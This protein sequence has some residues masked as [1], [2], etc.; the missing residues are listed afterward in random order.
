MLLDEIIG[1]LSDEKESLNSALLKT[2]VL[3][4][5]IGK[6]D[7]ATWVTNELKGYANDDDVPDYR[8]VTSEPHAHVTNIGWQ[9]FDYT[10]LV[11]HLE[12]KQR[13]NLT[14]SKCIL[15]I[16][17][18]EESI[19][20]FRA[21][22]TKLIRSFPPEWGHLFQKQLTPGTNIVKIWCEL[23]IMQIERILIEVRS[24][25]LDFALELR[26]VVGPDIPEKELAAKAANID[27]EKLFIG[28]IFGSGNTFIIGSQ[29]VQSVT[30]QKEDIEGLLTAVAKLG[31]QQN[32]LEELRKAILED[33]ADGRT[34]DITGGKTEKWYT[35]SIKEA[36]KGVIKVGVDVAASVIK[37]AIEQ[38][39]G[40][41]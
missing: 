40:G 32:D 5:T 29:N 15:S 19:R 23:N 25:L 22:G 37:K 27:T 30:N 35:K 7:L 20:D 14:V 21:S 12:E 1:I 38:Y 2:K 8:I 31:Y 24:R 9:H 4:H 34:P 39:V 11:Y 18:I 36:G 16:G 26:D 17:S 13:K 10:L 41:T 33:K 3:L 28:A 6:K